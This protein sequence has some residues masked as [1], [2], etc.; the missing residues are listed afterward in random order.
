MIFNADCYLYSLST[1]E[2]IKTNITTI[3]DIASVLGVSSI[4]N[5]AQCD[6]DK[7]HKVYYNC[8]EEVVSKGITCWVKQ[9][10][11]HSTELGVWVDTCSKNFVTG[12]ILLF[13]LCDDTKPISM[14]D[15][16]IKFFES[17]LNI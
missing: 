11:E 16:K 9:L 14:S 10:M 13:V 1:K 17:C 8:S 15:S 7:Y 4:D 2:T 5:V 6:I 3:S 12:D